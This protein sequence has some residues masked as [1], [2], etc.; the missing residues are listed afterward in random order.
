[1]NPLKKLAG[2]TALYGLSTIV[3]RLL[4]YL[5]VPLYTYQFADPRDF[6]VLTEFYAYASFLNVVLT[7]G[8]ETALF[9]FSAKRPD[10]ARVYS[11]ALISLAGT[12]FLFLA[13]VL[14]QADEL[15]ELLRYPG[16]AD[17]VIWLGWILVLDAF[18]AIPFAKLREQQRGARFALLKT[19]N[20][21]VNIAGN[22]F[23]IG[24]AKWA[25][26]S[27]QAGWLARVGD[28]YDPAIG[29]GYVF[30][31]NLIAS[32]ATGLCLLPEYL[33][34][35]AWPSLSLWRAML[36]Y[37]LPLLLTGLAGMVNE[38]LDRV[39]IKYLLPADSAMEQLGIYGACYKV[40]ILMTIFIQAFRYAAEPFFFAHYRQQDARQLYA[41]V[42]R[43]F[44]IACA[45]LFLAVMMNMAWIQYFIG[46]RYRVGLD[47]APIL[48]MA[49]LCL[50][51][52]FNL[53]IWYKLTEQTRFGAWLTFWGA[54]ATLA[55]NLW[56]IP[57]YGYRG[58]AWATLACYASMA[59]L[60]WLLGRKYY[61]VPY[62]L[63]RLL[64][65]PLLVLAIW[66]A[67]THLPDLGRVGDLLA[68]N[69]LLLSFVL[70]TWALERRPAL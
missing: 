33:A 50:G 2:Q 16:R 40:A 44:V 19:F 6:G 3:G 8:M 15:A 1:M 17:W 62:D 54:A 18:C 28:W 64:G 52:Y 10:K 22:L 29:I 49:N 53:S 34:A 36:R 63:K 21:L 41:L 45:F 32:V 46:A 39:L 69:A 14:A 51:V 66:F 26:D 12:G 13:A 9:N 61:P 70:L 5:L 65:Y 24:L 67:A 30:V 35:R 60:S 7:Y 56:W 23:F 47:I 37:A 55:L 38:T 20:I 25:H 27:G 57:A 58:A 68:R 11:T 42:M 4:N 48:L 59:A 43:W 31:A